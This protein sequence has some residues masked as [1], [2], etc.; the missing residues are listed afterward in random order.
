MNADLS[1]IRIK[2]R[3]VCYTLGNRTLPRNPIPGTRL[4]GILPDEVMC[5]EKVQAGIRKLKEISK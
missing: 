3:Y 4:I 1:D 2:F 5:A